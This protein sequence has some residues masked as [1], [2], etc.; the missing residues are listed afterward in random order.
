MLK[1]EKI[2]DFVTY[3]GALDPELR[4]FDIVMETK[5]G[6]TY[7]S[8]LIDGGD[9]LALV[10]TAKEHYF[11]E[12]FENLQRICSVEKIKYLIVNHTEPDHSG[13]IGK[14]LEKMPWLKVVGTPTALGFLKDIANQEFEKI[15]VKKDFKLKVG[16]KTLSFVIAPNLHWPDSM[17]T[18]IEEENILFTCDVFGAHYCTN[19]VF[20]DGVENRDNY[21]EAFKYYYDCIFGP[22]KPFVLAGLKKIEG[23]QLNMVCPSHGPV[24]R[25]N[26]EF[27]KNQYGEW[28]QDNSEVEQGKI[29]ICYTSAYGYTKH[30][31]EEISKGIEGEGFHVK[32]IDLLEVSVTDAIN[33]IK[34]SESF[35]IGS[36]T[37]NGDVVPPIWELMLSIG[38]YDNCGKLC[39]AFG[40]YGWSGEAVK[41]IESRLSSLKCEVYKPGLKIKFNPDDEKKLKECFYFGVKFAK[42]V[43]KT[44]RVCENEW[45][46]IRT[47]KWKC[48]VCGEI[49][50]GEYPPEIC[51]ACGAPADQFVEVTDGDVRYKS[52][53]DFK[54]LIIG[55]GV[56]AVSAIDAIR[57]RN[58]KCSIEMISEE[59]CLPYSRIQLSKKLMKSNVIDLLKDEKWFTEKNIKVSLSKKVFRV[60]PNENKI[61]FQDG[62]FSTYDKLILA[63]GASNKIIPVHGDDK[64]GVFNLRGRRDFEKITEFAKQERVKGVVVIGGGILGM[65]MAASLKDFGKEVSVVEFAPRIMLRQLDEESSKIVTKHVE[66]LG[67]RCYTSEVVAEIFGTG[68]GYRD[69]CG[70]KLGH[71]GE[72]IDCQM[73][74]E[75]TGVVPNID[76]VSS[77]S[78]ATNR[79]VIVDEHMRTNVENVFACG[80]VAEFNGKNIALWPIA[81]EQ[82]RVAGA[83]CVG[84]VTKYYEK[85]IATT[86]NE[87]G[88]KLFTIGDIGYDKEKNYQVLELSDYNNRTYRKFY[89]EDDEFVGG[90]LLGDTSKAVQL[91]KAMDN[92]STMQHFLDQHFLDE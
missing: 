47:G 19:N 77:T 17:F 80:D 59:N 88:L 82:A 28:S 57:Q 65:E 4:V 62:S 60:I 89:F 33:E 68:D 67:V 90:I 25:D 69:V 83:N 75:S 49:Y 76:V 40:S 56:A 14:L 30:M 58:D 79:G 91:R 35:L 84:D 37:I 27:Y 5:F 32:M 24:L 20:N 34:S 85:P 78:I 48:L 92:Q 8:Y 3:I 43:L 54:I 66:S 51:P 64:R 70:V 22:F 10:D 1:I 29:A 55:S 13:E 16:A 87:F 61:M 81:M 12:Y 9:E 41:G 42:K 63:N 6:T 7:N 52:E 2:N 31:A 50:E 46:Q 72:K 38:A 71:G 86:F 45:V 11:D 73:V 74:I 18:Y 36:P 23:L 53:D 39:A 15:E 26:I 21:M 44:K